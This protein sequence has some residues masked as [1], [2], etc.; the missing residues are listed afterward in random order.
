MLNINTYEI[1]SCTTM[2]EELGG[3]WPALLITINFP[4]YL[5]I[6]G[7][8]NEK[9]MDSYFEHYTTFMKD[10]I[11]VQDEW[12][13]EKT[14]FS[15][16]ESLFK[17][18][19]QKENKGEP[20]TRL[21][22]NIDSADILSFY[23]LRYLA[24]KELLPSNRVLYGDLSSHSIYSFTVEEFNKDPKDLWNERDLFGIFDTLC[25]SLLDWDTP[26]KEN[27]DA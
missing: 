25:F 18:I 19:K 20:F 21:H 10:L 17:E 12:K 23:M 13:G 24:K 6:M 11:H 5:F 2:L 15:Y 14:T 4:K 22:L 8:G 27:K 26:L 9:Y 1:E 16:Y 7:Y 3:K